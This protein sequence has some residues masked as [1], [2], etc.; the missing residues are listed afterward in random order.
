MANELSQRTGSEVD[1]LSWSASITDDDEV[2]EEFTLGVNADRD[3]P[4]LSNYETVHRLRNRRSDTECLN[5]L[6]E[7]LFKR[8]VSTVRVQDGDVH[9]H[10][11]LEDQSD[12]GAVLEDLKQSFSGV[13]VS[14]LVRTDEEE[15]DHVRIDLGA[16]TSR[17]LEVFRAAYENGYFA[18]P[19]KANASEVSSQLGISRSTFSEHLAAAQAKIADSIFE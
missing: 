17:Q 9:L 2:V 6:V 7:H 15:S 19:R 12:V 16:L 4:D 14:R 8:P 1:L 5:R 11:L 18:Y 3:P 13:R 10:V